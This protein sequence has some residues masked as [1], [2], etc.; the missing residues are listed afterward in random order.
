MTPF[1]KRLGNTLFSPKIDEATLETTLTALK[2]GLPIPVFWLLGKAQSGKTSIIHALTQ[3]D[4][5]EIGNGFQP[6]TYTAHLYDFPNET[7]CIIR[8]L[9]TRGLG[10]IDYDPSEDIQVYQHQTHVLIVVIKAMDH[11]QQSVIQ[12]LQAIVSKRPQWPIIVV[13]TA[14]HEGYPDA[15]T[16][17][18]LPYPYSETPL[19]AVIPEDLKRSLLK[20]RELFKQLNVHFVPVDFTLP[21]DGYN[22]ID[23]GLE[24]LWHTIEQVFSF[25][26]REI[27]IGG[28]QTQIQAIYSHTAHT[29]I[30]SYA[31]L[32]GSVAL[33]PTPFVDIPLILSIQAKLFHTLASLYEQELTPRRFAEI[34]S[35]LGVG[36]LIR[37]SGREL[38]KMI[39]VYGSIIT[40]TYTAATTYALGKTIDAYFSYLAQG[41]LPDKAVFTKIYA[42]EL[43]QGKEILRAY[44]Q[45]K[46]NLQEK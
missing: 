35:V 2:Q 41:N 33:V 24:A 36:F 37:L 29:H 34:G 38:T 23:Y 18:I 28:Q 27:V 13:Q 9:D 7:H 5:A 16:E 46:R 8:F 40:A 6:C 39:P 20:Q 15:E 30:I 32:A 42:S 22:P 10:E 26:I 25:G 45:L 19:P 12:A 4:S 21:E 3:C 1:W 11:A 31:L 43:A 17:H 14:L 44:L